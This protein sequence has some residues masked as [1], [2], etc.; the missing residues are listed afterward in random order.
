MAT[1]R[2]IAIKLGVVHR[3]NGGYLVKMTMVEPLGMNLA[4]L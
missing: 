4:I 1:I 3:S 2:E